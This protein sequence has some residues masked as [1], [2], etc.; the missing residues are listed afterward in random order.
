MCAHTERLRQLQRDELLGLYDAAAEAIEC[1]AALADAGRNPVTE[2]LG[3]ASVVEEWVHFPAGDVVD[4]ASHSQYYYH[5]HAAAERIAGEHGHFHT[6]MRP[7]ALFPELHPARAHEAPAD[8]V[9][10]L[11]GISTDA[12]GQLIRLF[13]TNRWVTGEVWYDADAVIRMLERFAITIEQPSPG[14]NRW[15]SAVIRLFRPQIVDLIRARDEAIAQW[16]AAHPE[17]D[18]FED[19]ELQVTSEM[20]VD[21]L[22]QVRAVESAL[23]AG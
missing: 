3:G 11:V 2:V 15:I 13:T 23:A 12:A 14:L 19:R 8:A 18:V 5:A 7:Q 22:E 6:F 20:P 9:T 16:R 1:V 4:A 21:F 10:H 17:R